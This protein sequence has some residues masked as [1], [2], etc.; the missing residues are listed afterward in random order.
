MLKCF[1][2]SWLHVYVFHIDIPKSADTV[3]ILYNY[4]VLNLQIQFNT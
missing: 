2:S 3:H 4:T 1:A